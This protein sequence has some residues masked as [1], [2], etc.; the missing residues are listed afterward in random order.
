MRLG[1]FAVGVWALS[2]VFLALGALAT[3]RPCLV[4]ASFMEGAVV[5]WWGYP[6]F[7]AVTLTTLGY[8]DMCPNLMHPWA[9]LVSAVACI[10][11]AIGPLILGLFIALLVQRILPHTYGRISRWVD[12]YERAMAPW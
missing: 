7:S 5:R 1:V 4:Y 2:N 10:E 8:G 9:G 12:E 6:Y 3:S 11:A